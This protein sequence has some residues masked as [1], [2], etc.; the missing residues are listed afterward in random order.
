MTTIESAAG[1]TPRLPAWT[2]RLLLK[3]TPRPY[4]E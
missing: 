3:P 1:P 2:F 4:R